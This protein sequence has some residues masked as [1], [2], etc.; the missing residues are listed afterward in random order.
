MIYGGG[1]SYNSTLNTRNC[2]PL[3]HIFDTVNSVWKSI[4]PVGKQPVARRNH[5][6]IIVGS[7]MMIMGGMDSLG[8]LLGDLIGLNMEI[9]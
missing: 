8:E 3:L 2:F 6:G 9:M 4:K 5:G 7:T 1:G